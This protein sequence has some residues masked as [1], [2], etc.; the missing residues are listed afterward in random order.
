METSVALE[1]IKL[2]DS[3]NQ[4]VILYIGSIIELK[5]WLSLIKCIG[6]GFLNV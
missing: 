3:L 5:I 4:S 1:L 2:T 6:G